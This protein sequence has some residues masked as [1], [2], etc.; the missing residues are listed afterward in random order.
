VLAD[1][2]ERYDEV[3]AALESAAGW[4]AERVR[5]LAPRCAAASFDCA[6]M[7]PSAFRI[8]SWRRWCGSASRSIRYPTV[9]EPNDQIA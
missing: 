5:R 8:S 2:R 6:A 1:L 7:A 4:Q 3:I 9:K